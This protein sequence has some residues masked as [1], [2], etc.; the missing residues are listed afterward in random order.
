MTSNATTNITICPDRTGRGEPALCWLRDRRAY[1]DL[2]ASGLRYRRTPPAALVEPIA[3]VKRR[4]M[5]P[6]QIVVGHVPFGT[7]P[8]RRVAPLTLLREDV[9]D[10]VQVSRRAAEEIGSLSILAVA[11]D[12]CAFGVTASRSSS[13]IAFFAASIDCGDAG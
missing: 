4:G 3:S 12:R 5:V 13:E 1:L 7:V 10:F 2:P 11:C 9:F 8:Q 6:R